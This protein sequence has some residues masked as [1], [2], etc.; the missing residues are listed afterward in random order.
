MDF[1]RRTLTIIGQSYTYMFLFGV[2]GGA[3]VEL[4]RTKFALRGVS[5]YSVF[6]RNQLERELKN[7]E[8]ELLA[9]EKLILESRLV[10]S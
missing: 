5:F 10:P 1:V 3:G 4:F 8:A 2:A 7:I 9:N 6:K